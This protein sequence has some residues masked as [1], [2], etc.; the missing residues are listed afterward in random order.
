MET[1]QRN[2]EVW[3]RKREG[4]KEEQ[5]RGRQTREG[6]AWGKAINN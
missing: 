4:N 5:A 3:M 6:R 1:R 2:E